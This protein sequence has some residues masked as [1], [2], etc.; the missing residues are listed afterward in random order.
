MS[1]NNKVFEGGAECLFEYKWYLQAYKGG[2]SVWI[3][4]SE[5]IYKFEIR[6]E[7]LFEK[8]Y[9]G[10]HNQPVMCHG[11]AV[12]ISTPNNSFKNLIGRSPYWADPLTGWETSTF[13]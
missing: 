12:L 9:S 13:S 1:E 10:T 2:I 8:A 11:Q 4:S 3:Y 6:A 7:D 5:A